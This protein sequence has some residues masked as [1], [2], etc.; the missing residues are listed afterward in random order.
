MKTVK[1]KILNKDEKLKK[2]MIKMFQKVFCSGNTLWENRSSRVKDRSRT[3]NNSQEIQIETVELRSEE[4]LKEE[5]IDKWIE[6]GGI[7]PANSP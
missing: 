7:A 4:I 3:R 2:D 5:Q 6:Q 1:T